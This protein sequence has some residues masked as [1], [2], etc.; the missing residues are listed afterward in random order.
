VTRQ[1]AAVTR[2]S[3]ERL[4]ALARLAFVVLYVVV[5]ALGIEVGGDREILV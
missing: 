4:A 3:W 1:E 5:F 2:I